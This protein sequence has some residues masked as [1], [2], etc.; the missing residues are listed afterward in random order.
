[1]PAPQANY[2]R[3]G[4]DISQDI[5]FTSSTGHLLTVY[6]Q[7]LN[8]KERIKGSARMFTRTQPL[9]TAAMADIHEHIDYFFVPFF[10]LH[11]G[12]GEALYLTKENYSSLI[13]NSAFQSFAPTLE[14]WDVLQE[15]EIVVYD[16]ND[17]NAI[18]YQS[19]DS[20]GE[21]NFFGLYRNIWHLGRNPNAIYSEFSSPYQTVID[22]FDFDVTPWFA[23]AYQ[24]VYQNFYRI[25]ERESFD[26]ASYNIDSYLYDSNGFYL[27]TAYRMRYRPRKL[28][29]FTAAKVS[30]M[31]N[32]LNTYGSTSNLT[33]IKSWLTSRTFTEANADGGTSGTVNDGKGVKFVGSSPGS[34]LNTSAIRGLFA[35]EKMASITTR[36]K[37]NYD[38]QVLAHLGVKVP[39]DVKHEI[40]YVG[41]QHSIVHI[42]EVISTADTEGAPIGDIVGKGYGNLV[43]N[44]F[45]FTA[46]CHG[47]FLAIYSSEVKPKYYSPIDRSGL[48]ADRLDFFH[49]EFQKLG[50][51]PI[52]GYE[53]RPNGSWATSV[54][55]WQMMY[56]HFKQK[57]DCVSPAFTK[58]WVQSGVLHSQIRAF[59]QWSNW[60]FV[61]DPFHYNGYD[62][63]DLHCTP[64]DLNDLFI[65]QYRGYNDYVGENAHSVFERVYKNANNEIV[66]NPDFDESYYKNPAVWFYN[67]PLL[68]DLRFNVKLVSEMVEN[69]MPDLD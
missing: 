12:L 27:T 39:H 23:L 38:S 20:A 64:F 56:N 59:N 35:A 58:H 62:F 37:K 26:A 46:P 49:P 36:S 68:H 63:S 45:D 31:F 22:T 5:N 69:T 65:M 50:M 29:Y 40:T 42:G 19:I 21:L 52:F 25:D 18:G 6:R 34:D 9:A 47:I 48:L 30:P 14:S 33:A 17:D 57:F 8:P 41:S 61:K 11:S 55:G 15:E 24:C 1:M 10:M 4:H 3:H 28:D 2:S 13:N 66:V 44:G 7:I 67:D 53:A 16:P 60:V 43:G 54:F 32:N 51:Q